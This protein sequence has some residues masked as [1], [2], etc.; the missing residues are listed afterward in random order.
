[1]ADAI[2]AEVKEFLRTHID[3]LDQ[4]NVLLLLY[5]E[6]RTWS[7]KDVAQALKVT[8][9][10]AEAS[11]QHLFARALV[12]TRFPVSLGYRFAPSS[13][14]VRASVVSLARVRTEQALALTNL[15]NEQAID[16]LRR[17]VL[18]A[19]ADGFRLRGRGDG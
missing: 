7:V 9:T 6:E 14:A 10:I 18:R 11:L 15:M 12:A 19:F 2:P 5:S 16:R 4:L 13:E 3:S 8:P 1:V 17:A